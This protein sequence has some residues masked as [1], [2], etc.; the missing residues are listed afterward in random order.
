MRFFDDHSAY[1]KMNLGK[2]QSYERERKQK[3][4]KRRNKR[5]V[6][7]FGKLKKS[8]DNWQAERKRSTHL[9]VSRRV[10]LGR[11]NGR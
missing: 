9:E 1:K 11:N 6:V 3:W 10:I 4:R 8:H 5:V 2:R 7:G